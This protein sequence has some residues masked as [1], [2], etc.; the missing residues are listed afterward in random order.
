MRKRVR[1]AENDKALCACALTL[2]SAVAITVSGLR[3]S[4][5]ATIDILVANIAADDLSGVN[6]END[7]VVSALNSD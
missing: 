1:R 5:T 6:D 3:I 7:T 2:L 4:T